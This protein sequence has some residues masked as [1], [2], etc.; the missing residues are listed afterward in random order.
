[1]INDKKLKQLLKGKTKRLNGEEII[2]IIDNYP[3]IPKS[4]YRKLH[5]AYNSGKGCNFCFEAQHELEGSGFMKSIGKVGKSIG[6]SVVKSG[7]G[8]L[9]INEAVG[10]LPIS[11]T[12][13]RA[14]SGAIS[15]TTHHMAGGGFM[16]SF[17]KVG[18]SIGKAADNSGVSDILIDE[19]LK[20]SGM[21]EGLRNK[22]G[23][24]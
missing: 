11:E 7:V 12:G 9:M 1:M 14:V 5:K 22:V 13:R 20:R 6:K 16:K 24:N 19:G 8:D 15:G 3:N 18:K 17:G 21:D 23:K 2:F 10:V 4:N